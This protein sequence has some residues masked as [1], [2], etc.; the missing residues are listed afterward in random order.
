MFNG[1]KI[2]ASAMHTER[3]RMEII[4]SNIANA[5]STAVDENGNI[6]K[7]KQVVMSEGD[8]DFSNI[9]KGVK[10]SKIV[11]DNAIEKYV[12][13]PTHTDAIKE[14]DYKG[15]VRFPNV[16]IAKE[17]IDLTNSQRA[18][19]ANSQTFNATKGIIESSLNIIK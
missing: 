15:Y 12:Y 17:I 18:F 5:N 3:Q 4:S 2:S 14:G 8:L 13:D 9:I 19:E 11:E 16:D 10:V 1:F 6:Y 7:R